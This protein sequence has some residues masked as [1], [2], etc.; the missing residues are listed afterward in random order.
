MKG[1][2][3]VLIALLVC[4]LT[5]NGYFLLHGHRDS[6]EK[7]GR[8][9]YK[10]KFLSPRIFATNQ[11][12]ML[13]NFV[14]LRSSLREI[15]QDASPSGQI[16]LYFEYLPSGVSIGLNEKDEF[17][18]A[19]LLK[20]PLVMGV[21]KEKEAGRLDMNEVLTL[22]QENID[23]N[24][25]DLWEKGPGA[26]ISV[27][28]AVQLVLTESDNTAKSVLFGRLPGGSIE[29]VF[30][31]LDIPKDLEQNM[32]VVTPKNYSSV[33]RSLYLS[34]YLDRSDSNEILDLLSRSK[35]TDKLRAGVPE[36]VKVAHK[37]GVYSPNTPDSVHTDC[38]IVYLPL[39]PY[40]LCLMIKGSEDSA[41][42]YFKRISEATYTYVNS[43]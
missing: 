37:I 13:V 38:G 2:V 43:Q 39:R 12:D 33:L 24:F 10:F 32:A 29:D 42:E 3:C 11:N 7:S 25:G 22:K 5:V 15:V 17:V 27:K 34:S 23:K 1:D 31:A 40:I 4:S 35:F 19:S 26:Q 8:S 6:H 9:E 20:V 28:D 30:D 14:R 18:L 21:Y 16:G 41:R 36:N